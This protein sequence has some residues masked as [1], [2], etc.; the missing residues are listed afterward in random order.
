VYQKSRYPCG[1][2][3]FCICRGR[4]SNDFIQQSGGLL[5]DGEGPIATLI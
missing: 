1:Y 4:D 3:L 2:L 5:G